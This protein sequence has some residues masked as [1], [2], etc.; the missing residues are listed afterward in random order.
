MT[1]PTTFDNSML[2]TMRQC[3]RLFYNKYI[4]GYADGESVHLHA[5]K[6]LAGALESARVQYWDS[7][8]RF[9]RDSDEAI[10]AGATVLMRL[11]GDPLLYAD[12]TKN[13]RNVMRAYEEYWIQWPLDDT[14]IA[15]H[16]ETGQLLVECHFNEPFDDRYG[17]YCGTPDTVIEYGGGLWLLDEKTT[18]GSFTSTWIS[19]WKREGQFL[20]LIHI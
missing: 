13:L 2:K 19:Q 15:R 14:K 3:E 1:I 11:W 17:H 5:G 18:G 8:G 7:M 12:E 10:L 4:Q 20:S 16:E 6:C 9:Y